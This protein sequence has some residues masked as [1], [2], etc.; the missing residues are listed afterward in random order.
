MDFVTNGVHVSCTPQFDETASTKRCGGR[1]A[2]NV[3]DGQ[4]RGIGGTGTAAQEAA[5]SRRDQGHKIDSLSVKEGRGSGGE[6]GGTTLHNRSPAVMLR[7]RYN[8]SS[9]RVMDLHSPCV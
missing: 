9:G 6:G 2:W 7:P 8:A 5:I 3:R 4:G 1:S